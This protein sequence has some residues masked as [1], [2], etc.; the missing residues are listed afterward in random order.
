MGSN[1]DAPP[2][3]VSGVSGFPRLRTAAA[4]ALALVAGWA[5]LLYLVPLGV[6][7]AAEAVP[8]RLVSSGI[9]FDLSATSIA[10]YRAILWGPIVAGLLMWGAGMVLRPSRGAIAL[11]V[12]G[13]TYAATLLVAGGGL[14]IGPGGMLLTGTDIRWVWRICVITG[15]LAIGLA[16]PLILGTRADDLPGGQASV[17]RVLLLSGAALGAML[18]LFGP[19]PILGKVM[20]GIGSWLGSLL[21]MSGL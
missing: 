9:F 18:L 4:P 17:R 5:L 1:A 13:S 15:G 11:G 21:W 12:V 19:G 3:P 6:G 2:R 14:G 7:I 20:A 8:I 10:G 16:G